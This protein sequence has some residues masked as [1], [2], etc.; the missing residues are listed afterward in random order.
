MILSSYLLYYSPAA[1]L[2]ANQVQAILSQAYLGLGRTTEA[3]PV[4]QEGLTM[5]RSL[6]GADHPDVATSLI[7]LAKVRFE[8]GDADGGRRLL[9]QG[10]AILGSD[11]RGHQAALADALHAGAIIE[12]DAGEAPR[13]EKL[14]RR[15]I[16]IRRKETGGKT[17]GLALALDILG[18]TLMN[19]GRPAQLEEAETNYLEAIEIERALLGEG[20][21]V[22]ADLVT[23]I[24]NTRARR[25]DFTGGEEAYRQSYEAMKKSLGADHPEMGYLLNNFAVFYYRQE[26]MPEAIDYYT[27]SLELRVRLLG[28]NHPLIGTTRAYLGLALHKAGDPRAEATYRTALEE[29]LASRGPGNPHVANLRSDLGTLLA[30]QGRYREADPVLRAALATLEPIFG[31]KDQRTDSARAG[32]AFALC[33]MGRHDDAEPLLRITREWRR[34]R[35]PEGHWRHAE[36]DL[37]EA[38]C[39]ATN[40]QTGESI[41]RIEAARELLGRTQPP[42]QS[43]L[44]LA[45]RLASKAQ[46]PR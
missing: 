2:T 10:L 18:S 21:R 7:T 31:E 19:Q 16:E 26:R 34:E 23:N 42:N 11:S 44:R 45:G 30:E 25:G 35:Y 13:A 17:R 3:E 15:E 24:A 14:V 9:D 43:L 8:Q 5:R 29:L 6:L 27:Q 32:L 36:L 37:Y 33:G 41:R 20:H 12:L 1:W 40:G 4:A 46:F 22:V 28:A 39:L 38:E